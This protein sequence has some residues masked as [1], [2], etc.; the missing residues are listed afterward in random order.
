MSAEGMPQAEPSLLARPL[1]WITR[2]VVR[3]PVATVALA[4]AAALVALALSASR[5]GFRTS[6]LDLL[7]SDCS[8][9]RLWIEYIDEFGDEDDVVVVVEGPNRELVVPVLEELS[10]A[11]ARQDRLFHA[12]L[13]EVDLSKIRSKGLHYLQPAELLDIER[14]LDNVEP[15]VHGD[16]ARATWPAGCV[17]GWEAAIRPNRRLIGRPPRPSLPDCR[18]VCWRPPASAA[19]TN[20]P[21]PKC[22]ARWPQSAN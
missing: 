4:V 11:L 9:N 19:G 5:L 13:H 21:G 3:F 18:R 17:S 6:R 15:I 22:L 10:T 7:N 8:Y 14:F 16:W 1:V 2:L 20:R 12:V